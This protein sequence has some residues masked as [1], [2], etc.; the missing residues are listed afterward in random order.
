MVISHQTKPLRLHFCV[1][2]GTKELKTSG[3]HVKAHEPTLNISINIYT[4]IRQSPKTL[5]VTWAKIHLPILGVEYIKQV[6]R[7]VSQ[8]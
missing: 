1:R 8:Y 4:Y 5:S 6:Q 2:S 7:E 3:E